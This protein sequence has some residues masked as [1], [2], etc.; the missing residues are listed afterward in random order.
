[1][2]SVSVNIQ[3]KQLY[4]RIALFSTT[5]DKL[6]SL[7]HL[8]L[9]KQKKAHLNRMHV[10]YSGSSP[11]PETGTPPSSFLQIT[12]TNPVFWYL[13]F[14]PFFSLSSAANQWQLR[15]SMRIFQNRSCH[16][17]TSSL[18]P[19]QV[20]RGFVSVTLCILVLCDHPTAGFP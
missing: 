11:T 7:R 16:S 20:A 9:P 6:F 5:A 14:N 10:K 12:E 13:D 3:Y 4:R 1:M 15:H 17:G 2:I 8:R 18:T 19:R